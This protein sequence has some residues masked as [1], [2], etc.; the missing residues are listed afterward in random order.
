MTTY[1]I[2]PRA[3]ADIDGIWDY[4]VERWNEDQNATCSG[5]MPYRVGTG[6]SPR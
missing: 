3:Q 5:Q 4:T 1:V 2:S 6:F